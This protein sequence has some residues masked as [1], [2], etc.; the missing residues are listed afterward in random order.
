MSYWRGYICVK[1][2]ANE[3]HGPADTTAT[4]SSVASLKSWLV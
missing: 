4:P 3:L 2:D 1:R